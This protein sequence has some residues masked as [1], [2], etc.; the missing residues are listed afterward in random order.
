MHPY[1]S[2]AAHTPY[3]DQNKSSRTST[4]KKTW[5][6]VLSENLC[7]HMLHRS[8][9]TRRKMAPI[10]PSLIT[11]NSMQLQSRTLGHYLASTPSLKI[12]RGWLSLVHLTCEKGTTTSQLK[13]SPKTCLHLKPQQ[14]FTPPLS[15]LLAPRTAW[16]QCSCH[17]H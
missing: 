6:E 8:S 15:C 9:I 16:L 11:G 7:R 2:P 4:S 12:L 14:D 3:H 10:D 5:L 13:K 17:R 1:H